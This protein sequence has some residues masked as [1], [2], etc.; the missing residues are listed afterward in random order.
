MKIRTFFAVLLC[1]LA[2]DLLRL[3]RRG[4]TAFPGRVALKVYPQ[5]L[6]VLSQGVRV[7]LVTGT[8]GK[9]TSSRMIEQV[10]TLIAIEYPHSFPL[11]LPADG[12]PCGSSVSKSNR[13]R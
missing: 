7:I 12:L 2:R 9:T 6:G 4:G 3:L 8:N 11:R 10:S 5:V 13:Y 1:K